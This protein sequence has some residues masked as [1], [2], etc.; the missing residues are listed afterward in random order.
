MMQRSVA[1]GCDTW[2]GPE[3]GLGRKQVA[4]DVGRVQIP[5]RQLVEPVALGFNT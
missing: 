4:P 5:Q 1:G 2:L 3:P